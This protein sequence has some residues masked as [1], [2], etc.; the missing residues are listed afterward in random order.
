MCITTLLLQWA[1]AKMRCHILELSN[2]ALKYWRYKYGK[3]TI[4][5]KLKRIYAVYK[6][7]L[8]RMQ[9]ILKFNQVSR[10]AVYLSDTITHGQL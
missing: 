5:Q 1:P 6:S 8:L 4:S 7:I 3:P 2:N 9:C 10:K